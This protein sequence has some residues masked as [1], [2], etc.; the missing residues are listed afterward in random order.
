MCRRASSASAAAP[1][2]ASRQ[3]DDSQCSHTRVGRGDARETEGD[4]VKERASG[5][6]RK[7]EGQGERERAEVEGDTSRGK[8]G[9]EGG[10]SRCVHA[11]CPA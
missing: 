11:C 7:G 2:V 9:A 1:V 5:R 8:E 6:E 4:G 10:C 3:S